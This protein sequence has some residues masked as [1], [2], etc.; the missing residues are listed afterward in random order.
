MAEIL[1]IRLGSQACDEIHWLV[2]SAAEQEIIA[3]GELSDANQ[4]TQLTEKSLRREVVT[5]VPCSDVALKSLNVPAKSQR[6]IRLAVPYMLED[7]LAQDVEQLFFAY[8]D[9]KTANSE[10]NCFVGVIEHEQ[11][12]Q[13]ITWLANAEIDC[14]KMLPDALSMPKHDDAW[15]A[16]QLG[17]QVL[18]SQGSWQAMTLDSN[19]WCLLAK[20][21]QQQETPP[22]I[23]S[24]S[25]LPIIEPEL[26]FEQQ[27]EEL[28]LALLAQNAEKQK[29]NLLQGEY[30]VKKQGSPI[31]KTW[32]WA[33]GIAVFALFMNLFVKSVTLFQIND[34]QAQ[35]EQE[36]IQ[37]Y[38][39]AF[40]KTKRVRVATIRSQLKSKLKDIG[41]SNSEERFL[42]MLDKLVPAFSQV[43]QLK[44]DSIKFDGKRNELRM[45][46]TANDYQHFEKFKTLLEANQLSVSQGAQ[47]NQGDVIS[48]SFSITN[49][50]KGS[51]S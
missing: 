7:E 45:Q 27:A 26:A 42:S 15:T 47:N 46:A 37:V 20:S 44:P 34:Q 2:W 14:K 12:Q 17:E 29:F 22:T 3:S 23:Y 36:I 16:V 28:P 50:K 51:R 38:K 6:A 33:A 19:V 13:W 40:P 24:Y 25:E 31:V 43:P 9:I 21:W 5:F 39:K 18:L 8:A 35:I 10:E 48:G 30:Q 41:S 32:A 49:N 11:M 4:L 1:Y